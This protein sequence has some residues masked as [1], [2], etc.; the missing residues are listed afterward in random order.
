VN[1]AGLD[2]PDLVVELS[3]R[4]EAHRDDPEHYFYWGREAL[5]AVQRALGAVSSVPPRRLMDIPSRYGRITRFLKAGFPDADVVAADPD[6]RALQF[7][8]EAL[9]V[10]TIAVSES[11]E[12]LAGVQERVDVIWAGLSCAALPLDEWPQAI[13]RLRLAVRPGGF[14]VFASHGRE[15]ASRFA[16]AEATLGL[17]TTQIGDAVA[18]FDRAG[19]ARAGYRES[20]GKGVTLARLSVVCSVLE[21]IE[22][23]AI[24]SCGEQAWGGLHDIIVCQERRPT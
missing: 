11:F 7:C 10:E 15:V 23:L 9:G 18:D 14:L 4:D 3:E 20:G 21:G 8:A 19:H 6:R 12:G 17:E 24:A 22:D 16:R 2:F 5:S 13:D 1:S